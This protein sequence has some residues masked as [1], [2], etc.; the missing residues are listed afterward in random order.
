MAFSCVLSGTAERN[1]LVYR[2]EITDNGGLADHNAHAVINKEPTT[3]LRARMDFN[4][5][6]MARTLR[7]ISRKKKAAPKASKAA[8]PAEVRGH[9]PAAQAIPAAEADQPGG[10]PAPK[11]KIIA[12]TKESILSKPNVKKEE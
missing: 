1:V 5:G 11:P 12:A 6:F 8:E 3:Y 9:T 7:Y 10:K 2:A 4:A